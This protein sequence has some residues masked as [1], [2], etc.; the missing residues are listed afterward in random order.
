[1][2]QF[3]VSYNFMFCLYIISHTHKIGKAFFC[4]LFVLHD[5]LFVVPYYFKHVLFQ[6][7]IFQNILLF[8]YYCLIIYGFRKT[9]DFYR[10][11]NSIK[12]AVF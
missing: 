10:T 4:I 3:T 11:K 8:Y 6:Q 9:F 7:Q 2:K 5:I 12:I 1:M